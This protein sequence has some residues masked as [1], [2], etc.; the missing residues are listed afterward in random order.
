MQPIEVI[1]RR[2]WAP[3]RSAPQYTAAVDDPERK[4]KISN[5]HC[6]WPS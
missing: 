1:F 5:L 6:F 3:Y 2:M 4:V